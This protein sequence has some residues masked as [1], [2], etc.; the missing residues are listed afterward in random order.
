MGRVRS[1]LECYNCSNKI[2]YVNR[3]EPCYCR[4]DVD[5][6]C[7]KCFNRIT[8]KLDENQST[9]QIYCGAYFVNPDWERLTLHYDLDEYEY[10][11]ENKEEESKRSL[12]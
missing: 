12:I 6:I 2:S 1:D 9:M 5:L 10:E 3:V 7:N 11:E 8:V 4:Q